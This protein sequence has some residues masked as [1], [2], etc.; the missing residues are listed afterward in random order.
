MIYGYP[1]D[2]GTS[3]GRFPQMGGA[4]N[5]PFIDGFSITKPTISWGSPFNGTPPIKLLWL[6]SFYRDW[7]GLQRNWDPL[8]ALHAV[9]V[10][11]SATPTSSFE[12]KV[13]SCRVTKGESASFIFFM[14]LLSLTLMCQVHHRRDSHE[15]CEAG[16]QKGRKAK[17]VWAGGPEDSIRIRS[18]R[19]PICP[20]SGKPQLLATAAWW[21][22]SP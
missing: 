22:P 7:M 13:A 16:R 8:K 9:D 6:V 10:H 21:D 4:R 15:R 20:R 3:I 5:R 17:E 14:R 12:E 11:Q 1:H 19:H 2:L 18:S